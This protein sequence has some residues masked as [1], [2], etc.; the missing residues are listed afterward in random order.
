MRRARSELSTSAAS[1]IART[2]EIQ[3][4]STL[5][6][7]VYNSAAPRRIPRSPDLS[8]RPNKY[9]VLARQEFRLLA[10]ALSAAINAHY[11]FGLKRWTEDVMGD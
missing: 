2:R 8:L 10:Q 6:S 3:I 4:F 5:A 1:P 11:D 9:K 7:S